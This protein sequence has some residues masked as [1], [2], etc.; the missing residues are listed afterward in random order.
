MRSF[1]E[2]FADFVA[3]VEAST[4]CQVDFTEEAELLNGDSM[5]P[6]SFLGKI[7]DVYA[8]HLSIMQKMLELTQHCEEEDAKADSL[9]LRIQD[10]KKKITETCPIGQR[11]LGSI[12]R[13]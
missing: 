8:A 4:G 7:P 9:K 5:R 2:S 11:Q 3:N 6:V 12:T 13:A 1:L 10:L